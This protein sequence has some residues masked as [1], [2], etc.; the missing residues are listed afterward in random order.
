ML[1]LLISYKYSM[2][3]SF[4]LLVLWVQQSGFLLW[5]RNWRS[6]CQ[7]KLN[8]SESG[9]KKKM[10]ENSASVQQFY[11]TVTEFLDIV[12]VLFFF[13]IHCWRLDSVSVF[14]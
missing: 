2:L 8:H 9:S 3:L 7:K 12:H 6:N 13:L 1:F 4:P 11:S 10:F 5:L 14:R